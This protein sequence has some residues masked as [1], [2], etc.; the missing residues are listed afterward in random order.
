MDSAAG[1]LAAHGDDQF[2]RE[3]LLIE[4]L[5]SRALGDGEPHRSES[6]NVQAGAVR[7]RADVIAVREGPLAARELLCQEAD[8]YAQWM[9][10]ADLGLLRAGGADD[11]R[12]SE[13][14]HAHWSHLAL[15]AL[16]Y[17]MEAGVPPDVLA[18]EASLVLAVGRGDVERTATS[19][20]FDYAYRALGR[21][22]LALSVLVREPAPTGPAEHLLLVVGVARA[23]FA[24]GRTRYLADLLAIDAWPCDPTG[25]GQAM[26]SQLVDR[27]M[28]TKEELAARQRTRQ[29]AYENS[30]WAALRELVLFDV[31]WLQDDPKLWLALSAILKMNG[32]RGQAD[33]A[34]AA[35]R[36]MAERGPR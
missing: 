27:A 26:V 5:L 31:M 12:L 16:R 3:S 11:H 6:L 14:L 35:A 18:H 28:P 9:R 25:L 23:V 24:T 17:G 10:A 13:T 30:D 33:L 36:S 7:Q 15:S 8:R 22:E 19:H 29:R 20:V 2:N 4:L 1:G 34:A 32:A 21:P